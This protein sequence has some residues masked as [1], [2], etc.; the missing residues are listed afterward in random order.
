MADDAS[1]TK[2]SISA[3]S[4]E[5]QLD[6]R[7][8]SSIIQ[9][10][11]IVPVDTDRGNPVYRLLDCVQLLVDSKF[12]GAL[13]QTIGD[14]DPEQMTPADR[15]KYWDSETKKFKYLEMV[16]EVVHVSALRSALAESFKSLAQ[17]LDTLPDILARSA[18]LS[19]HQIMEIELLIDD[20][21]KSL[22]ESLINTD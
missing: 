20:R 10:N 15:V 16:G 7:T 2:W 11:G 13:V 22:Y 18:N 21:R 8:V 3:L 6:R 9:S 19:T 5:L 1:T 12:K 14:V 17:L 4:R